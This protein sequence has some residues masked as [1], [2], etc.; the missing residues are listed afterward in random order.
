MDA[1]SFHIQIDRAK[2]AAAVPAHAYYLTVRQRA[3]STDYALEL[4][5]DPDAGERVIGK[6]SKQWT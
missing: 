5:R 6:I 3:S 1:S 2:E 4:T